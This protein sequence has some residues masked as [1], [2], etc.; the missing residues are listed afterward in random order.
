MN[1]R[2]RWLIPVAAVAVV[3]VILVGYFVSAGN[4]LVDKDTRADQ[5]FADLDADLQRRA[6][7]IPNAVATVKA[8][9]NQE[10]A[11]FG[12]LA[13][14]RANYNGAAT[15]NE[16]LAAGQQIEQGIGRLL[17]IVESYPQLRSNE[18]ILALQDQLE[19][20]EN[21]ITVARQDYNAAVTDYNRS[22]RRFPRS[23]VAGL[24]GFDKRPLFSAQP[25]DRNAPTVDFSSSTT[26]T[27]A[28]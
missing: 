13:R 24:R 16:K 7:L 12:E 22:I 1:S 5:A 15:Q 4:S 20:T 17:V 14:A 8:A 6:D 18:N 28:G 3:L 21:R 9:L 11:V 25:A 19:G 23:I 2:P 10:Q 27:A 26:T